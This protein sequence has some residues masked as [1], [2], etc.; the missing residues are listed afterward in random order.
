MKR[1]LIALLFIG[2][3]FLSLAHGYWLEVKGNGQVGQAVAVQLYFGEYENH[4]RERGKMLASMS[5]F[6]AYAI[7]PSGKRIE[8]PLRHTETCWDG[9][10]TPSQP[11]TYQVLAVNDTRGVQDWT[12]HGLGVVRPVEYLRQHYVAGSP[13]AA[14]AQPLPLDVTAVWGK[15]VQLTALKGGTPLAKTKLTVLNPEGWEKTVTTNEQGV[16]TFLPAGKGMYLV[17]LDDRG[18]EPGT[19]Q[20]K[21]YQG[22][23]T[24]FALTLLAD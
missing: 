15:T 21:E 10:F 7:D 20:G 16:A 2:L 1:T 13:T 17:E 6:K 12:R 4:L 5:D 22:V 14:A 24:K 11:G 19:F 18:K 9:S 23:R 3:P 8:I